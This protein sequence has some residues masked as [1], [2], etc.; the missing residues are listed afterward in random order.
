MELAIELLY[1]EAER[2]Q[3]QISITGDPDGT[4]LD[5]WNKVNSSIVELDIYYSHVH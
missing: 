2:L 5:R 4:Y 1:K 3:E